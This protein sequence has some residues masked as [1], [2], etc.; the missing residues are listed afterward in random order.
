[1]VRL[2]NMCKDQRHLFHC[3]AVVLSVNQTTSK[4]TV[5]IMDGPSML[6]VA[7]FSFTQM[8]V[9]RRSRSGDDDAHEQQNTEKK[10][11][12]WC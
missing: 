9:I 11:K 5:K 6:E 8:E 12:N 10:K 1:M 4:A 3:V 2:Q 7:T